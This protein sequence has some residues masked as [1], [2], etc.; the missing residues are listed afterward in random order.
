MI[1]CCE[2]W[3]PCTL[4]HCLTSALYKS[5]IRLL[6]YLLKRVNGRYHVKQHV[7]YFLLLVI[8]HDGASGYDAGNGRGFRH[9]GSRENIL[10]Q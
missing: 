3:S 5:L 7:K 6:T 1:D 8:T 10:S 9:R 4:I 2:H